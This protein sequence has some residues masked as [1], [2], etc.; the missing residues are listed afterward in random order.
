MA[1]RPF[2]RPTSTLPLFALVLLA[3]L[4]RLL[5]Q[6]LSMPPY[7]G[8]DE[9]Y[10]V[11][12]TSFAARTGRSPSRD[13]PSVPRYLQ[14]SLQEDRDAPWSFASMGPRWPEAVSLRQ[15]RWPNPRVTDAHGTEPVT[16]NYQSQ[17]PSAYYTLAGRVLGFFPG[18]RQ[19]DE[20]LALRLAAALLG[21]LAVLA[22]A[23]LGGRLYGRAGV[24]AG[25]LL[26]IAPT[27]LALVGRAGN[28]AL[29]VVATAAALVFSTRSR[30]TPLSVT[31]ESLLWALAIATK[32]TTWP[33]FVVA[34]V[35][36][37]LRRWPSWR[38]LAVGGAAGLSF[39]LTALD[40]W[41]RTGSPVGD[42]GLTSGASALS[43]PPGSAALSRMLRVF[44]A[45]A[46]WPGAQHG[47]ALTVAGMGLFV[48]PLLAGFV[49][50]C[51]SRGRAPLPIA[52]L[53]AAVGAFAVAQTV[54]AWGFV[55]EAIQSGRPEPLGGFEGWYLWTLG[56][57]LFPV[58]LG[59][60]FRRTRGTRLLPLFFVI[61]MIGWDVRIH[62]GALF[63]DYAGET[64]PRT[65]ALLFRWGPSGASESTS[66]RLGLLSASAATAGPRHALRA[67]NVLGL[68]ALTA[69][70]LRRRRPA[71][72][73]AAPGAAAS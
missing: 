57:L 25:A 56:P 37:R 19:L 66:D 11:A 71:S 5:L 72:I 38:I 27:W 34:A 69:L 39:S 20:L 26:G 59:Y 15:S 16:A 51:F 31:A 18:R 62:E 6:V 58:L 4:A 2:R 28:D 49:L 50:A 9:A 3:A 68:L 45:S 1:E 44:V 30:A 73:A 60:A 10:H 35:L 47:N 22:A 67:V 32:A 54:H 40:L 65:P 41:A 33:L 12:R 24:L 17:H 14:R 70:T 42:Q 48:L 8:L 61:W 63:P 29:A 53:Y 46:I 64:S 21:S 43:A 55:S 36:A 23:F 7:A 13:E 52:L